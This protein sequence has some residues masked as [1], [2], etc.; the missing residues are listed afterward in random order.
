MLDAEFRSEEKFSRLSIAF[1]SEDEKQKVNQEIDKI[2]AKYPIQPEI[3]TTAVSNGKNVLVIEYGEDINRESGAIF[4][5]MIQVL[6]ITQFI[7]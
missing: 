5:E 6:E 2:V 7:Q 3:Y 1:E 4:E